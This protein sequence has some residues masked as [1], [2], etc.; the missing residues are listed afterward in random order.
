M[1][2][3]FIVCY[4]LFPVMSERSCSEGLNAKYLFFQVE[5]IVLGED[6]ALLQQGSSVGRRG[7]CG[8]VFIFKVNLITVAWIKC[9]VLH[10]WKLILTVY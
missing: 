8:M 4:V 1:V 3:D 10:N 6:C 5:S 2:T 7:M 9:G